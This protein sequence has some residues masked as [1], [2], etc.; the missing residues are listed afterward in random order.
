MHALQATPLTQAFGQSSGR[1]AAYESYLWLVPEK[2]C[3]CLLLCECV[4]SC[5]CVCVCFFFVQVCLGLVSKQFDQ[6][7]RI[8]IS[9]VVQDN[10][11]LEFRSSLAGSIFGAHTGSLGGSYNIMLFVS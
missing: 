11:R 2:V 8:Y 4:L 3:L 7:F 6:P 1:H 10:D 5:V 9:S